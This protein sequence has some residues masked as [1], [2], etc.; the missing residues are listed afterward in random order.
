MIAR[1]A[2]RLR[3]QIAHFSGNLSR[4]LSKPARRLVE[5]AIYGIQARQSVHLTEIARSLRE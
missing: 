3:E 1:T 4:G 5:E 2:M